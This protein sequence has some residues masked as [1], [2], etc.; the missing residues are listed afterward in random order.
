M[1]SN[2]EIVSYVSLAS[3]KFAAELTM[4]DLELM[5]K[6]YKFYRF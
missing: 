4:D 5:I 1:Y 3:Q 2:F 6:F